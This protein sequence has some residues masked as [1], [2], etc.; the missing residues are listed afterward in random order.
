[1]RCD[2]ESH[3]FVSISQCGAGEAQHV[4]P[5]K[6]SSFRQELISMTDS[7]NEILPQSVWSNF[8]E[9]AISDDWFKV[10]EIAANL[11]VFGSGRI[12]NGE[13]K[14]CFPGTPK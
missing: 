4:R 12:S 7:W 10:Y 11:F 6:R 5:Q 8:K 9:I 13:L 1:M 14:T 3:R 2:T